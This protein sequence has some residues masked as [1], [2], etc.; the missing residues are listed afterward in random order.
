MRAGDQSITAGGRVAVKAAGDRLELG[1][2]MVNEGADTG[3]NRLGGADLRV[4]L[5]TTTEL[6]AEVSHTSSAAGTSSL[7][8]GYSNVPGAATSNTNQGEGTAYLVTVQNHGKRLESELYARQLGVGFGLGQQ[9]LGQGGT[10]KVGGNARYLL[11]KHWALQMEAYRE[12]SLQ[13]ASTR[14]VADAGVRYQANNH[15]LTMGVRHVSDEYPQADATSTGNGGVTSVILGNGTLVSGSADQAY[16]GGSTGIFSNKVTL[17]GITSQ[18]INGNDPAYPASTL[19]GVD[20]KMTD[21][22]TLF[23]NQQFNDGAQQQYSRMT[24]LGVR[25]TPWQ[26]AQLT[27]SIGQQMTEYGPRTFSTAGLTQGWQVSK[28]LTLSAGLNQVKSL[29]R[30]DAPTTGTTTADGQAVPVPGALNA[31][32]PSIASSATEDFTSMFV[33]GT[34]RQLVC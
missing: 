33:G 29:H 16:L 10:R 14:T 15:S 23:V 27:N 21:A 8:T 32:T 5:T 25:A 31:A 22:A 13:I 4:K 2:T 9:S 18:N 7:L 19:L 6:K 24:E 26:R 3:S 11:N 17:H 34:W 1:V 30:P 12:Q 28:S 20:Y